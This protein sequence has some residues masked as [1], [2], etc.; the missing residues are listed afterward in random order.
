MKGIYL[1]QNLFLTFFIVECYL[2]L[3]AAGPDPFVQFQRRGSIN[4]LCI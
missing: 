4:Y 1:Q 3:T 2:D